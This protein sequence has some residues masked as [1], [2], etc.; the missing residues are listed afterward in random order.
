MITTVDELIKE[1]SKYPKDVKVYTNHIVKNFQGEL[2]IVH[3]ET[4]EEKAIRDREKERWNREHEERMERRGE[5][6]SFANRW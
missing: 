1:L 2:S 5:I 6:T 4:P 3:K